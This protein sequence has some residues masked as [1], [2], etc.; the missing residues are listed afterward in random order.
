MDSDNLRK[1]LDI[2]RQLAENR[3]LSPLL[4]SAINLAIDLL[5]GEFG[6]LVLVGDENLEFRVGLDKNG[7]HLQEPHEQIS[8]TIFDEVIQS[9]K[10]IITEDAL[11]NF[12]TASVLELQ[13]RSVVCAPLISHGKILGAIYIENRTV[14]NIFDASDLELLEY[15]AAQAA[16][17]IENASLNDDLEALV[18][19][20][21]AEL[22]IAN[23]KLQEL[24]ITDSL[25]GVF[26]RRHLFD[27]AKKEFARAKRSHNPISAIMLDLDH[28]KQINDQHGHL[29]GDR[30]LQVV[31]QCLRDNIREID[32]LGRYGG[33]EFTILL[34]DTDLSKAREIAE[35]LHTLIG[36]QSVLV[37]NESIRV[38]ASLGVAN[39]VDLN[40]ISIEELLARADQALYIAKQAGRNQVEAW[41]ESH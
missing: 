38:T 37:E 8:R 24:A 27:L 6:Y 2:G 11:D 26:N 19:A 18:E 5:G 16:V 41:D 39:A 4:E 22:A 33:E 17:S 30:V 1:L 28:F 35:R 9:G 15:F 29:I 13:L 36:A 7:A 20:R 31:A 25:T 10:G 34:P 32:I 14:S 23:A 40:N 12:D 3:N 21:T